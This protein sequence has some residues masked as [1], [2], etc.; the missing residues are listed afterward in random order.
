MFKNPLL[1]TVFS[2]TL[3]SAGCAVDSSDPD[4]TVVPDPSDAPNS[5][6]VPNSS[7]DPPNSS[8]NPP[9]SSDDPPPA[10]DDEPTGDPPPP[11]DDCDPAFRGPFCTNTVCDDAGNCEV[12]ESNARVIGF[13]MPEPAN[14]TMQEF[15]EYTLGA[16]NAIRARTCLQPLVLDDC[17]NGIAEDAYAEAGVGHGY[18][19]ANCLNA[20][21]NYGRNCECNWA[22]EN[23][24][25]SAGS[26][27]TWA[28]GVHNPLCRMMTEDYGTGHRSNIESKNWFRVGV[29]GEFNRSGAYWLH[30][31]GC[32]ASLSSCPKRNE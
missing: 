32:D 19:I 27:R 21:H 3:A 24:G 15:R 28:D 1:F 22:Q 2:L 31:F 7:D 30:E 6:D 17:L 16:L 12:V 8:D 18:F 25:A 9:N 29:G 4:T 10:S 13:D 11:P 5:D 14:P 23:A 26:N 20:E